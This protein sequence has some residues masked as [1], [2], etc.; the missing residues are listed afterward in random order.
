MGN[1]VVVKDIEVCISGMKCDEG[2][3]VYDHETYELE[4][5]FNFERKKKCNDEKDFVLTNGLPLRA[6]LSLA[7]ECTDTIVVEVCSVAIK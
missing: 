3:C 1:V 7:T 4:C 6:R 2:L 5:F